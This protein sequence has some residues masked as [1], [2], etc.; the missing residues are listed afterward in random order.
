MTSAYALEIALVPKEID[1]GDGLVFWITLPEYESLGYPASGLHR[2]GELIYTV[3]VDGEWWWAQL[4]FS[5]DAMTFLSL[6]T[7]GS[8]NSFIRFYNHGI[9][10]HEYGVL[11]LLEGGEASLIPPYETHTY[12]QWDLG[13]H[14]D[15]ENHTLQVTT[16][17]QTIIYFDLTTGL[18]L[19]EEPP[20]QGFTLII[21]LISFTGI[22]CVLTILFLIRRKYNKDNDNVFK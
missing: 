17:E 14:H 5:D 22:I 20:T 12:D 19:T 1:L 15:R 4:Y 16:A 8:H 3:A 7:V 6:P 2:N 21:A 9:L 10:E 11:S 13:R 18:I